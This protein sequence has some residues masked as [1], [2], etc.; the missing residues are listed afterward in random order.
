MVAKTT[1]CSVA[2]TVERLSELLDE[3]GLRRFAVVDQR[4]EAR[5]VG[6]DLRETT[7]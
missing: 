5:A 2:D 4:A 1:S 6:L 3:K 7:S